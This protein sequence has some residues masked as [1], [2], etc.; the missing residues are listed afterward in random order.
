MDPLDAEPPTFYLHEIAAT[1][2]KSTLAQARELLL[3]YGRFVIAQ[4]GAARF[5]FGSLEKE[6]DALPLSFHVQ[7]GGCLMAHAHGQPAGFIAWRAV[8]EA[9]EPHAWELKRLWVR[10]A[11]RGLALGRALTQAVLERAIAAGRTAIYL[12]TA[13]ASMAAAYRMYLDLG[14]EP[15]AP[16]NDNPV[17]GLAY[18][19]KNL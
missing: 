16:Y 7:G 1:D 15:C 17:E 8:P 13:P 9:I 4:P 6:A 5:C 14:F 3:E 10:P 18:L 2:S 11:A 12:D 19:R